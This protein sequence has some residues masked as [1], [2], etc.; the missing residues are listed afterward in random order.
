[1]TSV[2]ESCEVPD[3]SKPQTQPSLTSPQR[4][5]KLV[6]LGSSGVGKSSFI[7]QYCRGHFP[8]NLSTTVGMDY[9]VRSVVVG[10]TPIALQLWDTAGQ[11]RFHSIAKQYYR[12]ADGILAMY[13]VTDSASFKAVRSCLDQAQDV[14]AEGVCLML[15]GNKTEVAEEERRVTITEGQKLAQEYQAEFYECSA[16]SGRNVDKAMTHL[17]SGDALFWRLRCLP[18]ERQKTADAPPLGRSPTVHKLPE[19]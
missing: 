2:S 14:T 8:N 15:L 7:H 6:F 5:F 18:P 16:K 10:N 3:G 4:V 17:A 9:Q 19:G 13:D 12:K 11:E 1:M